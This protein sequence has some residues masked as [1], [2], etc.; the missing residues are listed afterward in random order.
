MPATG[1]AMA[2]TNIAAQDPVPLRIQP[3]ISGMKSETAVRV[4]ANP[5]YSGRSLSGAHSRTQL[6]NPVMPATPCMPTTMK[7]T[8]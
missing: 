2:T 7:A 8:E 3:P 4:F 6:R 1:P 5:M